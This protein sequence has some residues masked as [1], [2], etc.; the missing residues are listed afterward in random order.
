MAADRKKQAYLENQKSK[1]K[2]YQNKK[3]ED[4]RML[5]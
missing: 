2:E 4:D 5:L 3:A 1:L